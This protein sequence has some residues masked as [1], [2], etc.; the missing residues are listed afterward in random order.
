MGVCVFGSSLNC[1]LREVISL[2]CKDCLKFI[3]LKVGQDLDPGVLGSDPDLTTSQLR[4]F[5]RVAFQYMRPTK[6]THKVMIVKHL[7]E[8]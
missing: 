2:E 6:Q 1:T 8:N 4:S 3:F 5:T 7:Y